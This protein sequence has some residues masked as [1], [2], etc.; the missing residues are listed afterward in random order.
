MSGTVDR[1]AKVVVTPRATPTA[2]PRQGRYWSDE[3]AVANGPL[4]PATIGTPWRAPL[5]IYYRS[6]SSPGGQDV[7]RLDTRM[8]QIPGN[9]QAMTYDADGNLT[10]DG[11]WSYS[12][13]GENRLIRLTTVAAA[14]TGYPQITLTFRYDYLGRRVEKLVIDNAGNRLL[15]G[16]R[17]LYDG[18]NLIAEYA[19][20][21]QLST[22]SLFRS[23]TWGLDITRTLTNA[24]GVGALLQIADHRSGK[25]YFPAYDGNGNITALVN[26]STGAVAAAYEYSPFGEPLRA[27]APDS[28]VADQPFRFSTKYTDIETG[29]VYYGRRYYD[30]KTGRFPSR[31]PIEEAGGRNLYGFCGNNGVNRF[32]VL[33]MAPIVMAPFVVTGTKIADPSIDWQGLFGGGGTVENFHF[34]GGGSGVG[35][36]DL[37]K[38]I[39]DALGIR[40]LTAAELAGNGENGLYYFLWNVDTGNFDAYAATRVLTQYAF[41]NGITGDL[42]DHPRLAE[43]HITSSFKLTAGDNLTSFTL[44]NNPASG[45]GL[46]GV[47]GDIWEGS[48]DKLGFTTAPAKALAD[49]LQ[50]TQAAGHATTWIAHSQGGAIFSQAMNY[51]TSNGAISLSA[52]TVQFNAG[53]N[54][55]LV[56]NS[57]ARSVGVSVTG[58][59]GSPLDAVPNVGGLN[60]NLL[61][62]PLSTILLPTL[63]FKGP[64]SHTQP[65]SDWY[66]LHQGTGGMGPFPP[67]P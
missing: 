32:D 40:R 45:K 61:T 20:N 8:A 43:S 24:G 63:F 48:L 31:D 7:V 46:A 35:P 41:V 42:A 53:V 64:T 5:S 33:G 59:Y 1:Y 49:V 3:L 57:I 17:F 21:P 19:L 2:A 15:T 37:G 36:L 10:N 44:F 58:Y 52:N 25:T 29:L 66:L 47:L 55:W 6:A 18:W 12:W 28:V 54:N 39:D 16:R 27:D 50:A 9:P 56:T 22:L 14:S 11:I 30:P 23:Y 67:G 4:S 60:G 34:D 26:S 65:R 13:D 51:A 38:S 62:I